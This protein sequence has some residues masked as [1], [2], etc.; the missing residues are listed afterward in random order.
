MNS[1]IFPTFSSLIII[2]N[3]IHEMKILRVV[4]TW[5]QSPCSIGTGSLRAA[6]SFETW[7]Y[8]L[9]HTAHLPTVSQ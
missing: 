9:N 6:S 5:K 1:I 2:L 7:I 4:W 8:E 3:I